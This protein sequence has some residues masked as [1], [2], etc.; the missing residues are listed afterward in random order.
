M[1]FHDVERGIERAEAHA[2]RCPQCVGIDSHLTGPRERA[3]LVD[4]HHRLS[5]LTRCPRSDVRESGF[6]IG[7]SIEGAARLFVESLHLIG[8]RPLERPYRAIGG[9]GLFGVASQVRA[10]GT[11]QRRCSD[12]DRDEKK[13]DRSHREDCASPQAPA[14][15]IET[16][17]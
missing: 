10:G 6:G 8:D 7:R 13:R 9:G 12:P 5:I 2:D 3:I 16:T 1:H 4:E 17:S 11:G 15:Y 14:S